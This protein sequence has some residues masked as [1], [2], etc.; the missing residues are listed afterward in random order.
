MGFILLHEIAD[1]IRWGSLGLVLGLDRSFICCVLVSSW[2]SV[3][4]AFVANPRNVC[5][6]NREIKE[7]FEGFRKHHWGTDKALRRYWGTCGVCSLQPVQVSQSSLVE[8]NNGNCASR[9][10]SGKVVQLVN[11]LSIKCNWLP[12]DHVRIC[13][14][15]CVSVSP[16]LRLSWHVLFG[17][18]PVLVYF[19]FPL[20]FLL[21][22]ACKQLKFVPFLRWQQERTCLSRQLSSWQRSSRAGAALSRDSNPETSRN[23]LDLLLRCNGILMW[24]RVNCEVP[25]RKRYFF[26]FHTHSIQGI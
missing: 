20:L 25:S 18:P 22:F 17:L 11:K 7:L 12:F 15:V 16:D 8:S 3:L 4:S 19:L 21:L 5:D 2:Q 1:R 9:S 24:P 26:F 23:L 10:P 6:S 14:F 13:Q